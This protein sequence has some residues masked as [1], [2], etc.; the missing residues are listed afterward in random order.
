MLKRF[1]VKALF[2]SVKSREKPSTAHLLELS[3]LS[4]LHV[5]SANQLSW[6]SCSGRLDALMVGGQNVLPERV[7][8]EL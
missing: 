7:A 5:A 1:A 4:I 2:I 6:F 8:A 3:R